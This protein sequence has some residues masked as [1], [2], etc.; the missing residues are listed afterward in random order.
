MEFT[1]YNSYWTV[2]KWVPEIIHGKA[3]PVC[4]EKSFETVSEVIGQPI[5][6]FITMLDVELIKSLELFVTPI[7]DSVNLVFDNKFKG[8][9]GAS[10]DHSIL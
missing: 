9:N 10:W 6:L 1:R 2:D 3:I 8:T 7:R 4:L 5:F